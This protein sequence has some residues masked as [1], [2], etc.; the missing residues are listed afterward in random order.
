MCLGGIELVR[1]EQVVHGIAPPSPVHEPN[2]CPAGGVDPP[3]GLQLRKAAVVGGH[4][5]VPGQHQL[6]AQREC[7]TLY[8][9]HEGFPA[10]PA[11]PHRVDPLG[12]LVAL[13]ALHGVAEFR[14]VQP[15]GEVVAVAEQH[16][17]PQV[18]VLVEALEGVDQLAGHLRRVAVHLR[19]PI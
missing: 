8:G 7:H 4:H 5:N 13:A 3:Q 14:Q 1:R 12:P 19:R 15:G 6:N 9:G 2:S 18:V 16:T 11:Q 10:T 17:A